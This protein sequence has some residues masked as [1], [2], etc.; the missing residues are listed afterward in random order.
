MT[1]GLR[2]AS[3]MV[4]RPQVPQ[5]SRNMNNILNSHFQ[6]QQIP[7]SNNFDNKSV[8]IADHNASGPRY[9]DDK[10][11]GNMSVD[12]I[13]ER[14]GANKMKLKNRYRNYIRK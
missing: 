10:Y 7:L 14:S 13:G 4:S 5:P 1:Q 9:L 6:S 3:G 8:S 2:Q 11:G 12:R